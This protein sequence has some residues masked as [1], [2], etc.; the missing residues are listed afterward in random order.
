MQEKGECEMVEPKEMDTWKQLM[1]NEGRA[2][3]EKSRALYEK[4]INKE[5]DA[6]MAASANFNRRTIQAEIATMSRL[7]V[8]MD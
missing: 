5:I 6:S 7:A 3:L 2:E 8:Q 1:M 4:I